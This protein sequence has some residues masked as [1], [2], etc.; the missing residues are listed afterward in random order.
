MTAKEFLRR[1][2]DA[3]RNLALLRREYDQQ[4]EQIDSIRNAMKGKGIT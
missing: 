4:M 2:G 1:Y 3:A